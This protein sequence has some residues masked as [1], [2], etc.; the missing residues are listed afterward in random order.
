LRFDELSLPA[1]SLG[2]KIEE[3]S[4]QSVKLGKY[5]VCTVVGSQLRRAFAYER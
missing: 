4:A 3:I 2:Q 1:L 5:R